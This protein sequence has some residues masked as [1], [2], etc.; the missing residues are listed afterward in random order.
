[1]S[2]RSNRF[3]PSRSASQVPR[4][5]YSCVSCPPME[6]AGTI[7]TPASIA[8]LTYPLRPLKSMTFSVSVGR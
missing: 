7:G 1:M 2:L 4:E 5:R 3:S 6:T 8:V